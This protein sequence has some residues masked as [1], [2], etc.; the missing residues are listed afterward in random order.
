[1]RIRT[2]EP[3]D[4]TSQV[5]IY[6][7]AAAAYP[8]FKPTTLPEVQ[9]RTSAREFD[10]TTRLYAVEGEQVV[11][12]CQVHPSGRVSYPWCRVGFEHCAEPLFTQA[13]EGLR[14]RGLR[15][16]YSAYRGDWTAV[17]QF[18]E[19]HGFRKARDVVNFTQDL[20]DMPTVPARPSSPV[21]ALQRADIA[22]LFKIGA[23]VLRVRSA[24]ELERHL[25]ENPHLSPRDVF[26]LRDR[27]REILGAALVV[28]EPTYADPKVVDPQ[29]PCFRL[30]A[31]G[32]EGLPTKRI[33]GLFSFL[34]RNDKY[35]PGLALDALSQAAIRVQQTEDIITFAAQVPS[36]ASH[37]FQF[38]QR[39]FRRQGSFPVYERTL[40]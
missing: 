34:A 3:G 30:G 17:A 38:Y 39:H 28:T 18:L 10:A 31:F 33:K 27:S 37:L 21:T 15:V 13:L 32:T 16:A 1:V 20:V 11:G 26:V 9:R 5:A 23:G 36:D 12:Y 25:F 35:L 29:M 8:N 40:V 4:E 14:G 7:E 19:A 22:T 2:F 24:A 6:N